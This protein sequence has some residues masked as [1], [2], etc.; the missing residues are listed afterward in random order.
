LLILGVIR[1][2]YSEKLHEEHLQFL[3]DRL[4]NIFEVPSELMNID[5]QRN[6]IEIAPWILEEIAQDLKRLFTYDQELEIGIA[7]EY[8]T[9][10]RLQTLFEP[11]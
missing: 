1:A 9:W 4:T 2:P 3:E 10:D 7:F 11:L 8:P 5:M 6:R